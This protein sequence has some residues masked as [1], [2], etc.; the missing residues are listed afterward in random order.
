MNHTATTHDMPKI[1][2]T[3]LEKL[4]LI[5]DREGLNTDDGAA[6][7]GLKG[8]TVRAYLNG[9]RNAGKFARLHIA[10]MVAA[11]ES[12]GMK[13]VRAAAKQATAED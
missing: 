7:I 6:L 10:N 13:A 12:G 3:T 2:P 8:T 5:F 1:V 11:Y 4:K 9:T